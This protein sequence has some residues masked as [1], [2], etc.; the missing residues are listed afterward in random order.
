MCHREIG[1]QGVDWNCLDLGWGPVAGCCEH[2]K[3]S[4][5]S[6]KGGKFHD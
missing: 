4:S 6:I 1:W 5:G 2:G 3:E